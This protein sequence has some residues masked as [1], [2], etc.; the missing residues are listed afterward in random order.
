MTT[1]TAFHVQRSQI[2]ATAVAALYERRKAAR[3]IADE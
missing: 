2:A 3:A 1:T